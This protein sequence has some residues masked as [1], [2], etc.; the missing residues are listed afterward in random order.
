MLPCATSVLWQFDL[1]SDT[2]GGRQTLRPAGDD[3]PIVFTGE[4]DRVYTGTSATCVLR[5]PVLGR[6]IAIVKSGSNSTVVWN[7]WTDKAAAME[8]FGADEWPGMLCIETANVREDAV[9][10]APGEYHT[11]EAMIEVHSES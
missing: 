7:P 11:M 1:R 10:L 4:T 8:D 2:A 6:R 5:D 3:G 9:A